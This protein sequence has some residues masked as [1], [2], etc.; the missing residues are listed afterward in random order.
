MNVDAAALAVHDVAH[1][2]ILVELS[3][4]FIAPGPALELHVVVD[5]ETRAT[6]AW[7]EDEDGR[8]IGATTVGMA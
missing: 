7:W 5:E 4:R 3:E 6:R 2:H 1:G 8:W